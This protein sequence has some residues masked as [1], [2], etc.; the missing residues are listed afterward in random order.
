MTMRTIK[1]YTSLLESAGL[2]VAEDGGITFNRAGDKPI[3]V[4]IDDKPVVVPV[5][6]RLRQGEFLSTI[7]FH[8]LSENI[9]RGESPVLKRLRSIIVLRTTEVFQRLALGMVSLAA[10]TEY[11]GKHMSVPELKALQVITNADNKSVAD[12]A[13]IADNTTI[14]GDHRLVRMYFKRGGEWDGDK[15]SRVCVV[16]F[17]LM[18][19]AQTD[20]KEIFGVKLRVS[21]KKQL[22][23]LFEYILPNSL[24]ADEY[25]HGSNS[26]AAPYFDALLRSYLKIAKRLNTLTLLLSKHLDDSESMLIDTSWED[27]L[28]DLPQLALEIP[29]LEGNEGEMGPDEKRSLAAKGPTGPTP[30]YNPSHLA[31]GLNADVGSVTPQY[32]PAPGLAPA[33]PTTISVPTLPAAPMQPAYPVNVAPSSNGKLS[34]SEARQFTQPQA[35]AAPAYQPHAYQQPA[36]QPPAAY[37][38]A[39]T[40]PPTGQQPYGQYPPGNHYQ[41]AYS[42]QSHYQPAPQRRVPGYA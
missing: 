3:V 11:H 9:I 13:K 31:S 25:S 38:G 10:D 27:Y 2:N 34:W 22:A 16:S 39:G 33:M 6:S 29:P 42:Q 26:K 15:Y 35:P 28:E 17:P 19:A 32:A 14:A 4:V 7:P 23:A 1:L 36:Y 21:D 37:P 8:P 41:P 12:L 20:T 5:A 30:R 24:E 18:E 40:Y